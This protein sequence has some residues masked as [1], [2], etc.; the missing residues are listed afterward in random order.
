M[1]APGQAPGRISS[2]V[3][4]HSLV[5]ILL[6]LFALQVFLTSLQTS[7]AYD[8]VSLLPSGY[9][10]LKTGQWHIFPHHTP[11][12]FALSALPLLALNPHLDLNDPHLTR[13]SPN[14][15]NVG[16]NFLSAN[17][18]DDR[19]AFWHWHRQGRGWFHEVFLF[20]PALVL[21]ILISALADPILMRYLLPCY[22]LLF[23][24]ISRTAPLFTQKAAGVVA[25]IVL[26]AWYL[27]TPIRI[28]PDYLA[29]FNEFVG[30]PKQGSTTWTIPTSTGD[31]T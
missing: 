6:A 28:Y 17:N 26:A 1:T 12:I 2:N 4:R 20:L 30:G 18:D 27:S 11:L 13:K 31:S 14:P 21:F 3:V 25:G 22:P 16:L 19:L 7:P 10:L 9:V 5:A 8:E 29:Y 23:I 15:W 24:F